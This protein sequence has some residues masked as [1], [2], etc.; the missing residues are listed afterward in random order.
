MQENDLG[1]RSL[2]TDFDLVTLIGFSIGCSIGNI[3]NIIAGRSCEENVQ[4]P[5]R[6]IEDPPDIHLVLCTATRHKT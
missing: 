5:M 2:S 1:M 6:R 3:G 4:S